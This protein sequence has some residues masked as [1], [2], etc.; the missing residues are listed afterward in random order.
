MALIDEVILNISAGD[1]G[2]GVVQWH[3]NR[4]TQK[5]GPVGGNGGR[6][7]DVYLRGVR[8]V[9]RL[10][11]YI[12]NPK[13]DA[14][15]G[16]D[17]GHN[18][19]EGKDGE[20]LF[21]D[22][23]IGSLITNLDSKEIPKKSYEI[24]TEGETIK[25]LSGGK[26]G[27]GN[28]HFK[29]SRNVT[30]MEQTDGKAGERTNFKVELRLIADLGFVG[31]PN[32]GKSTLLSV[33]TNSRAKIGNYAFTTLEPNL[34]AFG[35]YILA[36]IPGLIEGAS[37]GKGLGDKFLRHIMRTKILV[38]CISSE[39]DDIQNSYNTIRDEL[40]EYDTRLLDKKELLVITKSDVLN[41]EDLDLITK[42]AKDIDPN[43]IVVSILDDDS[44]ETLSR[45]LMVVL[46]ESR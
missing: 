12:S 28:E 42:K 34:G 10:A 7:A 6:G 26:G 23:P 38:H 24:T 14:R 41:N 16:G 45:H 8:D 27:F 2:N 33:L 32:A 18:S 36:D 25:I 21:I 44:M 4:R 11:K 35:K 20:D 22:I 5:G 3:R 15:G 29:S 17:G 43:A 37:K 40:K 46:D 13:F 31:Y 1:G 19:L 30:P 9:E 39:Q